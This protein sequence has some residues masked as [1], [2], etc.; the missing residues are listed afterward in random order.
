MLKRLSLFI[1]I[2]FAAQTATAQLP[3]PVDSLYTFIKYNSVWRNRMNWDSTDRAF[4]QTLRSAAST[5]DT[6]RGLVQ[7]LRGLDDVHTQ[8][9][10]NNRYFGHYPSM[11]DSLL[12]RLQ[13]LVERSNTLTN[14]P[15][16]QLLEEGILWLQL[17]GMQVQKRTEIP[18]LAGKVTAFLKQGPLRGCIID[19]RLNGGGNLYPMLGGLAP[20]LGDGTV[21]YEVDAASVVQRTWQIRAGNFYLND[22]NTSGLPAQRDSTLI[23]LPV[24]I[25][26]GPATRSSGSMVAVAFRGRP[27][28]LI[29]GE[30]TARGYTSSNNYY[31]FAPNLFMNFSIA[32]VADRNKKIYP[33]QVDPDVWMYTPD[34]FDNPATDAK[35]LAA[36][37]WIRETLVDLS[38]P[39]AS[40]SE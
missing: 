37:K 29:L 13:P 17:P 28:T 14:Q 24:V 15:R 36:R 10:Y 3:V 16:C 5:E 39:K 30:P 40:I 20:L 22:Y 2:L 9:F 32:W 1:C 33:L 27:H 26:T 31:S 19:L 4:Q 25:L 35:L 21:G 6:L 8:L 38:V 7:V 12:R 18:E 23:N 34:H 11:E